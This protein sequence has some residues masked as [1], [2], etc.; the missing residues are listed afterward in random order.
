MRNPFK[1]NHTRIEGNPFANKKALAEFL[2]KTAGLL[3]SGKI[4]Q[5]EAHE[6]QLLT[7]SFYKMLAFKDFSF[8]LFDITKPEV[9]KERLSYSS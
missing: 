3:I 8:E 9:R 1:R 6:V 2:G 5:E 7:T 4:S